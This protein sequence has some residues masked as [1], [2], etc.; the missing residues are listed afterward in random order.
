MK[1]NPRYT[2]ALA[3]LAALS[4]LTLGLLTGCASVRKAKEAVTVSP[5]PALL[6]PDSDGRAQ[7]D[8]TFRVP[9]GYLSERS[10]L[11][12]LPGLMVGDSVKEEYS[13]VVID[14][15]IYNKKKERREVLVDYSDPYAG[16]A[17]VVNRTSEGI[18]LPYSRTILLPEGADNARVVGVVS[19]DGCGE[20]SAI[21]TIEIAAVRDLASLIDV[22]NSLSLVWMDKEFVVRPKTMEGSGVA[23]LQFAINRQ[24]IDLSLGNNRRELENMVS[25]LSPVLNDTLATLT[26]LD[27]YGMASADGSLSYNTALARRRAEAASLWLVKRLNIRPSQRRVIS[28]GSRSEGW[29]PV[30]DAMT[31]DGNPDSAAVKEILQKYADGNDDVQERYIRRLPCWNE[32]CAKYLQNDRKVE[33]LYSYVVKSFTSDAELLDMYLKR[34]DAFNEEE[35]LRVAALTACDGQKKAVYATTLRYFPQSRVAAN[36]LAVLCLRDGNDEAAR[37]ALGAPNENAAKALGAPDENA[38]KSREAFNVHPDETLNTLAA[39]YVYAGD[40]DRAATLLQE[41]GLPQARYNLGLVRTAQRR[42]QQAYEL[43]RPFGD[44]NSAIAALNVDRTDE[45]KEMLDAIRDESPVTE[46]VR[47]LTAARLGD[48]TALCGHLGRACADESLRVRAAGEADFYPYR[49]EEAF[50]ALIH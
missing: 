49:N 41:N 19:T 8:V 20:C 26:S 4:A 40:Y 34:P 9:A 22:K 21:D 24:D 25:T 36:N 30:L 31:A 16:H 12:I 35:L 44:V 38:A 15:P 1:R 18:D 46:Y 10:R 11:V 13:P 2:L 47:A 7:M 29:Q 28:V 3:K 37:E 39:S 32:I 33:Y 42:L 17:V 6:T 27:I 48:R 50:R 5:S 23:N 43:L 14:A 45:A